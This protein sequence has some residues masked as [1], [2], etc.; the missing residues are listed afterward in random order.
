M[1]LNKNSAKNWLFSMALLIMLKLSIWHAEG[2][3]LCNRLKC[4]IILLL[5]QFTGISTILLKRIRI[6]AIM[7]A[8]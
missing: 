2:F 5:V 8:L 3:E 1:Q 4:K 6:K 7:F